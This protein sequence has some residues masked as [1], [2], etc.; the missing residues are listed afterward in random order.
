MLTGYT[1]S[2][3]SPTTIDAYDGVYQDGEFG[4]T[5]ADAFVTFSLTPQGGI[6]QA[7]ME[8]A[9]SSVDFSYDFQDLV[10]KPVAK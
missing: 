7:R 5:G 9:S 3:D 4:R 6:E 2:S 8:P 1:R 10:L